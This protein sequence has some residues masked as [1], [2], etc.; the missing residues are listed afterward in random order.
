[1]I[2]V[3]VAGLSTVLVQASH[4]VMSASSDFELAACTS[5]LRAASEVARTESQAVIL[6]TDDPM[7]TSS[8]ERL[9]DAHPG[10]RVVCVA[11]DG[12]SAALHRRV[13]DVHEITDIRFDSILALLRASCGAGG[14]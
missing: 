3:V 4:V 13:V 5:P 1:M 14:N 8:S 12:L 10:L 11:P 6:G 7:S 2:R 9:L